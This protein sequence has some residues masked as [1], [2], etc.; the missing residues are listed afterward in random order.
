MDRKLWEPLQ[1]FESRDF[2][3]RHYKKLHGRSLNAQRAHEIGACFTQGREYFS[4]ASTAS[5]TVKPLLLYYGVASLSKGTTLLKDRNKSEESLTPAHGLTT[6]DWANILNGGISEVLNLRIQASRGLFSEFVLAVGNE[7][8]YVWLDK[9]NRPGSFKNDF[10]EISFLKDSSQLTL[11]DLLSREPDLLHEF[12]IAN[13]GWGNIDLG[14]V[15]AL[16]NVLRIHFTFNPGV[17]P[18]KVLE[19]HRFPDKA[20]LSVEPNPMYRHIP[21]LQ[22]LCVEIPA[23]GDVRKRLVP[24]AVDQGNGMEWIIRPLP[25]GDNIVDIHRLFMESFILGMFSRYFPSKWMSLL[26]SEKGDIARSVVLAAIAR[27]ED[28]FPHLLCEQLPS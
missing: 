16:D 11:A 10:G 25:N 12:E 26:R 23:S 14:S 13:D 19:M 4:S 21:Q 27:I 17:D 15:V 22:T 1:R 28:R 5:E 20:T 7:Q 9:H 6:V 18:K 8:S 24:L 2:L 3:T